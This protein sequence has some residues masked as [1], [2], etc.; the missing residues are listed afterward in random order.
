M[1]AQREFPFEVEKLR[2]GFATTGSERASAAGKKGSAARLR[3][4]AALRAS[5]VEKVWSGGFKKGEA[6]TRE[7]A[8][9]AINERWRKYY[10][11]K[12]KALEGNLKFDEARSAED[13]RAARAKI[14]TEIVPAKNEAKY[15][16]ASIDRAGS[17]ARRVSGLIRRLAER[18]EL[19]RSTA[20]QTPPGMIRYPQAAL[21]TLPGESPREVA[22]R[23][24]QVE[25]KPQIV[26]TD[27][28]VREIVEYTRE[29]VLP[30][31][32]E[33]IGGVAATVVND[34]PAPE[35]SAPEPPAPKPPAAEPPAA[36]SQYSGMSRTVTPP[37]PQARRGA[38]RPP[39]AERVALVNEAI[40]QLKKDAE[41]V[42]RTFDPESKEGKRK[43]EIY[44]KAKSVAGAEVEEAPRPDAWVAAAMMAVLVP[45]I[46]SV[47]SLARR[48]AARAEDYRTG[49]L[50]PMVLSPEIASSPKVQR[51]L[52][53]ARRSLGL[54]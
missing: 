37:V 41:A 4:M 10:A 26:Q 31:H 17:E 45:S 38:G 16:A 9:F 44:I 48:L 15:L 34:T 2:Q 14:D 49:R 33:D 53:Q 23:A 27:E 21:T 19:I 18:A 54:T 28:S 51:V 52:W 12:A 6:Y 43:I 20:A 46:G 40:A 50:D 39:T 30:P 13:L 47:V 32:D 36:T 42:G 11:R 35:P 25:P 22:E 24:R 1:A 8:R 29:G 5:G 3:R 7:V